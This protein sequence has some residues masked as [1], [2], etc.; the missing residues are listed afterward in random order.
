MNAWES[1]AREWAKA[2]PHTMDRLLEIC[3]EWSARRFGRASFE[4]VWGV[5][6]WTSDPNKHICKNKNVQ[7]GLKCVL[8]ERDP[9]LAN[10]FSMRKARS[11]P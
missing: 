2:N 11:K 10:I 8:V 4:S 6:I 3:R 7:R 9:S 1:A 5:L